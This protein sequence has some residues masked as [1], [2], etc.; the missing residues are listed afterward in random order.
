LALTQLTNWKF[1]H[2]MQVRRFRPLTVSVTVIWLT[3]VLWVTAV[4]PHHER[5]SAL[6]TALLIA[7]PLYIIGI[8]VWRTIGHGAVEAAVDEARLTTA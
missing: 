8:G 1:V 4:S 3:T 6:G 5:A 7:C 2:P